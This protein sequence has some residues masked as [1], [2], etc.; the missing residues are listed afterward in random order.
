MLAYDI[1]KS[2]RGIESG[3]LYGKEY[4]E[5]WSEHLAEHSRNL[6]QSFY[7]KICR[8]EGKQKVAF[9]GEKHPHLIECIDFVSLLYPRARYVYMIRDPRD[10]ACSLS[11]LI[12]IERSEALRTIKPTVESYEDFTRTLE[13]Q[14]LLRVRYQDLITDYEWMAGHIFSWLGLEYTDEVRYEVMRWKD[15]DSHAPLDDSTQINFADNSIGRWRRE[16]S[17]AERG[18]A[19]E[20]FSSYLRS[21]RYTV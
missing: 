18:L 12:N 1:E 5:L 2:R 3:L 20:L 17:E 15:R 19:E 4:Y 9:W 7:G 11:T 6:I 21:Y 14:R 13:P 10:V 16:F 8:I